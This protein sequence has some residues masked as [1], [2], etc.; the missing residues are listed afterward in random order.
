MHFFLSA[1]TF[2]HYLKLKNYFAV[3]LFSRRVTIWPRAEYE[4][5]EISEIIEKPRLTQSRYAWA[6]LLYRDVRCRVWG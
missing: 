4:S 3:T 6:A 2:Y 5:M 1:Y